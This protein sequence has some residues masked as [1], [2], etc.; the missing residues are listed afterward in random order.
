MDRRKQI[1]DAALDA[2]ARKGYGGTTTKEIAAAAGVTEAIVFRHF[3][4]KQALYAAVMGQC[5]DSLEY[6][7]WMAGLRTQVEQNDDGGLLRTIATAILK[8]YRADPRYER[9]MLF[10]ALEG[11]EQGLEHHRQSASPVVEMLTEYF[12]RRQRE[13][14]LRDLNVGSIIVSIAGI[15]QY[16]AMMLHMFGYPSNLTDE[17]AAANFASI[18][19]NGIRAES[20]THVKGNS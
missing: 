14:A 17:E 5:S 4:T 1:L 19:L 10:A 15:A 13:G 16:Y 2:F 20:V 6:Q 8:G 7:T 3:P 9:V 12:E 11:H 18:I